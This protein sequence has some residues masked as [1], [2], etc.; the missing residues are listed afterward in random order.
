VLKLNNITFAYDHNVPILTD[1]SLQVD[2]G[3]ILAIQGK[4]GSGK[5]TILR[6][7]AGLEKIRSGDII[8]DG[9]NINDLEVSQRGV[10]YVFQNHALFPH[11]TIKQNI[12]FGISTLKKSYRQQTVNNVVKLLEIKSLLN[13]YPHEISG[14]QKQRVAIAR[15]LVTKPKILLLDEPFT[16]LDQALKESVRKDIY[17]VLREYQITTILVTHDINDAYAL[18][19]RVMTLQ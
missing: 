17:Q 13:R 1:F 15:S 10:G 4:S 5:S 11:L 19:A 9:V 14:G 6:L 8:L 12:E 3:E 18:N 16:A 7:I 2:E